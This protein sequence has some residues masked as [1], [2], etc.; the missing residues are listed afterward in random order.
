MNA[1][2]SARGVEA[3][4]LALLSPFLEEAGNNWVL[5]EKGKLG[6]Y[7]QEVAGDLLLNDRHGR[8][9][10][11]ELKA[12][13]RHTGNLFLETWS[14]R[15]LKDSR[16]HADR[17]SN[18]GWIYKSRADLLF[19]HFLDKDTLYV[20]NLFHLKQWAF[21]AHSEKRGERAGRIPAEWMAGRMGDFPI[22]LQSK[23][24]QLNDTWGHVVPVAVLA[25]EMETRPHVTTVAQ[26][27]LR[28]LDGAA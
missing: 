4:S 3:R 18:P 27:S 12:E 14:N 16:S 11:V 8:L 20:L 21:C 28:L 6:R 24:D 17:G 23:Y 2:N 15:N 7:L 1:F 5:T 19:Y 25:A 10:C 22:R 9:W 13:E 26:L